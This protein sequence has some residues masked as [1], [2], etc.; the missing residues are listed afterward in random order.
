MKNQ[1]AKWKKF[2]STIFIQPGAL[3]FNL[4]R[5]RIHLHLNQ[6]ITRLLIK[7]H[8]D[9][10]PLRLYRNQKECKL[11]DLDLLRIMSPIYQIKRFLLL[12]MR[13][14]VELVFRIFLKISVK[15]K[16]FTN[17]LKI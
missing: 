1:P 7:H 4:K 12:Q 3:T 10:D 6:M 16:F 9:P 5:I 17:T 13:T 8:L 2:K 15:L 14:K 11:P